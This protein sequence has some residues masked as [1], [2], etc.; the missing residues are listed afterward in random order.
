MVEKPSNPPL[1]VLPATAEHWPVIEDFFART[2]CWC[3]YWR[4]SAGDYGRTP[5]TKLEGQQA[6]RKAALR[7]QLDNPIAPGMIAYMD[8]QMV[9]WCGIG[10]RSNMERLVRSRTIPAVDT[11]PVW[12]VVCFLVQPGYRRKGVAR[13]LLGA[14]VEYTRSHGAPALEGY[15]VDSSG[16]RL[17]PSEVYVGTTGLFEQ[18]GFHRVLQT[19]ARSANRPRWI[20]RI[21]FQSE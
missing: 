1:L 15:P 17:N 9:G 18:A 8:H 7:L 16:N 12:S 5:K 3:Q 10:L 11:R 19:A 2:P 21:D 6:L 20:M 14:A 4:M 13:V